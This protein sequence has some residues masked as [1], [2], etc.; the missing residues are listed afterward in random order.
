MIRRTEDGCIKC[1]AC[2]SVC[3]VMRLEG[4]Q[5][6]PG[7]RRLA[8]EAPRFSREL[9]ALSG[10]LQMCTSCAQCESACP[11]R[12]PITDAIMRLRARFG[13]STEGGERMLRNVRQH[14]RTV[15][16]VSRS[17]APTEGS[18]LF[19]PGCIGEART[20]L[21]VQMT[22]DLLLAVGDG[23]YIP[24][25]WHCCGSPLQKIG[26]Q[27]EANRLRDLNT[28][29]LEGAEEVITACPGC[30]VQLWRANGVEALHVLEYLYESIT[31]SRL[32]WRSPRPMTVAIHSPCHL[33]R[34]VGPHTID[35]AR[36]LLASVDGLRVVDM[37][38]EG[39]CG[40]G[41]GVASARPELAARMA[42]RRTDS[43]TRAGAE[44]LLAPCPFCVVNLERAGG[45]KVQ[46]LTS[47]L[48]TLSE[49]RQ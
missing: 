16:P 46:D 5:R 32:R 24:E 11:S 18:A 42:R 23:I 12:L 35:Y 1:G 2:Q 20:P 15:A 9:A 17:M 48:A 47:F 40:G 34:S 43:A 25:R 8:V 31:P 37:D 6:F 45:L 44:V 21:S 41:G 13:T 10:P 19:F 7:P 29:I 28:S 3:P 14:G 36:E 49:N 22:L 26:A 4:Y 39:C 33:V 38:D 27:D 30:A